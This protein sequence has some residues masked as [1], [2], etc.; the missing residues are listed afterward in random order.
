MEDERYSPHPQQD[1][2]QGT[3][4]SPKTQPESG[5]EI[6]QQKGFL[7]E[8]IGIKEDISDEEINKALNGKFEGWQ[9]FLK[10]HG[11]DVEHYE[12]AK[13]RKRLRDNYFSYQYFTEIAHLPESE[14]R[15]AVTFEN[16]TSELADRLANEI[17]DQ[18]GL[19][20]GKNL[21][22]TENLIDQA[23]EQVTQK[24]LSGKYA[25]AEEKNYF[26]GWRQHFDEIKQRAEE[27]ATER[28]AILNSNPNLSEE[29]ADAA[30]RSSR[31]ELLSSQIRAYGAYV[32]VYEDPRSAVER[33]ANAVSDLEQ[34]LSKL[35]LSGE[36]IDAQVAM[37]KATI[38]RERNRQEELVAWEELRRDPH[39][40]TMSDEEK[41]RIASQKLAERKKQRGQSEKQ[42][43]ENNQ[44]V[45]E[46]DQLKMTKVVSEL[47]Q[48]NPEIIQNLIDILEARKPRTYAEIVH[49]IID[50]LSG[51]E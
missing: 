31:N 3:L 27:R 41:E 50:F 33:E 24:V 32:G 6:A 8:S 28:Q 9:N 4:S 23:A 10:Q 21:A 11:A 17:Y 46:P 40:D 48:N 19:L 30:M 26:E 16:E 25:K 29:K 20:L 49:F 7:A 15:E 5:R 51:N 38:A 13:L 22:Y 1:T 44:A 43:S 36:D 39:F 18:S 35:N 12:A 47:L 42:H 2:A 14:A 34:E 37:L 45:G